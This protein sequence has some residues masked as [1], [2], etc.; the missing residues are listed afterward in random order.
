MSADGTK[1]E[2]NYIP[3]LG[4]LINNVLGMGKH[5]NMIPNLIQTGKIRSTEDMEW[6]NFRNT[7]T[8]TASHTQTPEDF[9]TTFITRTL[10]QYKDGLESIM[11]ITNPNRNIASCFEGGLYDVVKRAYEAY[12][13]M[14]KT[15]DSKKL[16]WAL[17]TIMS[18]HELLNS[19]QPGSQGFTAKIT[20]PKK[21][22]R[23]AIA[24]AEGYMKHFAV[25]QNE[26]YLCKLYEIYITIG[27][28]KLL[29]GGKDA[30]MSTES[31]MQK[32]EMLFGLMQRPELQ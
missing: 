26:D 4:V 20:N 1:I 32:L 7:V 25:Q 3:Y 19:I 30:D 14:M 18:D 21:P 29:A 24:E 12:S 27:G 10:S 5:Q 22:A 8:D 17:A 6:T 2:H 31:Q 23:T 28:T 15:G 16:A 13:N 11:L 9:I